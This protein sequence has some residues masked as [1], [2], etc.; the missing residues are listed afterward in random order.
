LNVS[1]ALEYVLFPRYKVENFNIS[2]TNYTITPEI[3][4]YARV[5][6]WNGISSL[7]RYKRYKITVI[8]NFSIGN[9][10]VIDA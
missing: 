5:N 9:Y 3:I 8:D 6:N 2:T 7:K 4:G 10:D 1:T